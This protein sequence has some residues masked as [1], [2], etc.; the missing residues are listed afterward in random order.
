MQ[1]QF[2]L[3]ICVSYCRLRYSDDCFLL[4]VVTTP[5]SRWSFLILQKL[6]ME[7][8]FVMY[9]ATVHV[10]VSSNQARPQNERLLW[11]TIVG[12]ALKRL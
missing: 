11:Y 6:R 5:I 12:K 1:I 8:F 2:T 7:L 10:R 9:K 3:I 4:C